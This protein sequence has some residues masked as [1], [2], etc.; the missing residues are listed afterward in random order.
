MWRY[1]CVRGFPFYVF[2]GH[3]PRSGAP[4]PVRPRAETNLD[5]LKERNA[6]AFVAP[7]ISKRCRGSLWIN[8]KLV[9]ISYWLR[10]ASIWRAVDTL[11][12]STAEDF[13]HNTLNEILLLH[14]FCWFVH[15]MSKKHTHST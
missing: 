4:E 3:V 15:I 9:L 1:M 8:R 5:K 7:Q 12:G 14:V 11:V 6:V 2:E 13:V 10:L